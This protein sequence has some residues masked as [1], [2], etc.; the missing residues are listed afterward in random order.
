MDTKA[1]YRLT[2]GLFVL[3]AVNDGKAN[4]CII[5]TAIQAASAPNTITISVNK[6]DYTHDMIM[7]SRRFNISVLSEEASFDTFKQFGFQSGRDTDKFKDFT[8]WKMADNDIPIITAGTNAYISCVVVDTADLGSHTMFI[9]YVKDME[10]LAD[11]PSATYSYYQEHIK[12][13]R[14]P[15]PEEKKGHTYWVCTVCGYIY[16]GED[17]PADFI[18]PICKHPAE[19]FEKVIE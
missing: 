19:D 6:A 16:D 12:P 10:V 14:Q 3:T 11:T 9:A 8:D 1:M 4:G 17:L 18:C 5:N 2:Y 15:A 7:A 13:K